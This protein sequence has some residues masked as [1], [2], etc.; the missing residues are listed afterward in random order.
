MAST[1]NEIC[2]SKD[3]IKV[4]SVDGGGI[5]GIIPAGILAEVEKRT[6]KRASAL[7]DLI[8]GTSTGGILA[9]GLTKPAPGTAEPAF[10]AAE[11]VG[12]YRQWGSHIFSRPLLYCLGS[13]DGLVHARYPDSPI[14]EALSAFFG[15]S[16]LKDA[17]TPLFIPSYEL[18]M[19]TP[20]FFRS[21]MALKSNDY[22]FAMREVARSTSAAP[23]YFPP[24]VLAGSGTS[25]PYILIDGGVYANNP[26]LCAYV[27]AKVQFPAARE[28]TVV[29]LGT[30]TVANTRAE[31]EP[32]NWGIAQWARPI[33]DTVLGGISSTV[34]YQLS[35]LLPTRSDGTTRYYRI[36]PF[37][38]PG[39][40]AMDD[41]S[42]SNLRALEGVTAKALGSNSK[43]IDALCAELT[44]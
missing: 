1:I 2:T 33:L 40:D 41:A 21:R 18:Q 23:T 4:L 30:G 38:P 25:E 20:F 19:K 37:L 10:T 6:G 36:Q 11:L 24:K 43:Q 3:R 35:Q 26:A 5:R 22:D 17:V 13:A 39:H 28:I 12:F 15:E 29:S 31:M 8:A 34:D 32:Q 16:R 42:A 27:E 9:L 14:E 7:F 44:A